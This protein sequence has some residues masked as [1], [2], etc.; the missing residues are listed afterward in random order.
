MKEERI[1]LLPPHM[2]GNEMQYI[3]EAFDLNWI[4]PVGN[5]IDNFEFEL[6]NYLKP[7]SNVAVLNSGTSAIHLALVLA[8]VKQNDFVLCQSFTFCGTANPILYLGAN[9]IFVDS[10]K[11][12]WNICPKLLEEAI[13]EENKKGNFPKALVLVHL[14]G[15]PA[16]LKEIIFICKKYA[17]LIIE[18]AAEALGST[19]NQIQ[20]GTFGEYGILSFNGNKIITTSAGGALITKTKEEKNRAIFLATQAKEDFLH[21]EHKTIGFNY[22]MSN[23]LAGIGRGQLAI[24]EKRIEKKREIFNFYKSKLENI[25]FKFLEELEGSKS[26]RW[27]TCMVCET[28][29]QKNNIIHQL[30][31]NDIESRPLWKPM[32]LQPLFLKNTAYKNGT[33]QELFEKGICLPS[34]TNLSNEQLDRIINIIL[35]S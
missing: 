26:N 3:Q 6:E 10:E 30:Q 17:I 24:L 11:E 20:C 16:K 19:Y 5:N 2:E 13:I 34:G 35:K 32:H 21:Y 28:E 22:R 27:L 18:D 31:K 12:T 9:P 1:Y 14:Y 8:G 23:I 33:S 7:D 4:A 15:V 25:G 29:E